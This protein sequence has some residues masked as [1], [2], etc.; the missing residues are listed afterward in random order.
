MTD[1]SAEEP[2]HRHDFHAAGTAVHSRRTLWVLALTIVTM[3][4]EIAAGLATGSLAL[5]ADGVHMA[6]HAGAIGLAAAAYA[7]AR[8][9]ARDPRYSFGTGKVGDLAG[10]TSALLLGLSAL[11]IAGEAVARIASPGV[12]DFGPALLVAVLGLVVN[13][14][15]ALILSGGHLPGGTH[16]HGHR[17]GH[18]HGHNHDHG[19]AHVHATAP[20][21]HDTAFRATYAHVVADALTSVLAIAALLAGRSL[22]WVWLD[23]AVGLLGAVLIARWSWALM[24]DASAVLLDTADPILLVEMRRRIEA[25]EDVRVRDLHVWRVGPGAHAAVVSVDG[26][27]S[28]EDVR[29]RLAGLSGLAHLTVEC[30]ARG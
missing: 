30:R 4:G 7:Y 27:A 12:V 25:P 18:Q 16:G 5:L 8:A 6:T 15:S 1:A 26:Q 28:C 24:R 19:H 3:V 2:L 9:H 21:D 13:V 10:F 14:V 23:P 20:A 17:H 29:G 22:G 11:G